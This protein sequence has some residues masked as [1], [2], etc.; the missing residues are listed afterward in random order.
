MRQSRVYFFIHK[1]H[2]SSFNEAF[3]KAGY[4][5]CNRVSLDVKE[6]HGFL[7][8]YIVLQLQYKPRVEVPIGV[9][10]S[11]SL[12]P[13]TTGMFQRNRLSSFGEMKSSQNLRLVSVACRS[14]A[15]L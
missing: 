12:L 11:T 1:L 7:A 8:V 9:V 15:A 14:A 5:D 4:C 2:T 13:E 6:P 3:K 10:H